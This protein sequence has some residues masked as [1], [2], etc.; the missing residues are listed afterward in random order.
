MRAL[1]V[2]RSHEEAELADDE[3][4]ASLRPAQRLEILLDLIAAFQ[5]SEGEAAKGFKRVYRVVQLG[6]R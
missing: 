3:F 1:R 2:F 5:E 4:Y 6:S